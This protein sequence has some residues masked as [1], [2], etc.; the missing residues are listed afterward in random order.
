MEEYGIL[1]DKDDIKLLILYVLKTLGRPVT[2]TQMS[3]ALMGGG[4]AN[5]FSFTSVFEELLRLGHVRRVGD[6]SYE[7]TALGQ[8]TIDLLEKQ[9]PFSIRSHAINSVTRVLNQIR[10]ENEI[11]A[12]ITPASDGYNLRC[13]A[14]DK[15]LVLFEVTVNVPSRMQAELMKNEFKRDPYRLF[16][17]MLD[18]LTGGEHSEDAADNPPQ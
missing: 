3:D 5:Y 17:S 15:G 11:S 12:E 7:L 2:F 14:Q 1:R 13:R 16:N 4:G 10:R 6:D 18:I 9:I 8:Q